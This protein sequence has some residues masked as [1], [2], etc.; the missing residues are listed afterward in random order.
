MS[1]GFSD[2]LFRG[3]IVGAMV[4]AL[5]VAACGCGRSIYDEPEEQPFIAAGATAPCAR[6]DG[7]LFY[8]PPSVDCEAGARMWN[9]AVEAL[10]PTPVPWKIYG[11]SRD[12]EEF[13]V[14]EN[15]NT[16]LAIVAG[17]TFD[18][19]TIALN[20]GTRDWCSGVLLYEFWH[21]RTGQRNHVGWPHELIESIRRSVCL[22][23]E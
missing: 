17:A 19:R 20:L 18:N 1:D 14:D 21:A 10:G 8:L 3:L 15:G 23:Q 22:E 5:A 12:W 6:A 16:V 9:A 13:V 2:G 11:H 7:A 4:G